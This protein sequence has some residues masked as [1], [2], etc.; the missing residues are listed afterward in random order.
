MG[1][2][3]SVVVPCYNEEAVLEIFYHEI[4][5]ILQNEMQCE[6]YEVIFVND[7][8]RDKTQDII[9]KLATED[10]HIEFVSLSRNFGKESAMY[11]GLK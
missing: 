4:T 7:G 9:V 6:N 1:K 10:S 11:A 2:K 8:S 3:I 5:K